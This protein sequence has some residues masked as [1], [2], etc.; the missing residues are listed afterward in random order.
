MGDCLQAPRCRRVRL[1]VAVNTRLIS[2][3]LA[4]LALAAVAT[5]ADAATTT[6]SVTFPSGAPSLSKIIKG[7]ST[8]VFTVSP[9]TADS[10]SQNPPAGT[11]GAALLLLHPGKVSGF[12][13]TVQ[14]GCSGT[15]GQC[16]GTFTITLTGTPTAQFGT[17]SAFTLGSTSNLNG[18]CQPAPGSSI[19][20]GGQFT[21][22]FLT[23]GN[24]G[25]S[26]TGS[27]NLGTAL[28]L[29]GSTSTGT[30]AV[31]DLRNRLDPRMNA[32]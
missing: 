31:D 21:F 7:T 24:G 25:K 26:G 3:I 4:S 29:P 2:A 12:P 9:T 20:N 5:A 8:T 32:L 15:G 16:N 19:A 22:Q 18:L 14:V 10:V 27:F 23:T 17:T 6:I 28:S 13:V 30:V 11:A 1:G